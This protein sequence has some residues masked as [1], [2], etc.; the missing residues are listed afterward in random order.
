MFAV[1]ISQVEEE[2]LLYLRRLFGRLSTLS[3]PSLITYRTMFINLRRR[4][5]HLVM[6]YVS[7]PT[8]SDY[9]YS[10]NTQPLSEQEIR[11]IMSQ[12]LR[13]LSFL[14]A[15]KI[16][17]RDIKPDNILY[18]RENNRLWLIDFGVSKLMSE[19]RILKIMM[20]NTGTCEYKAP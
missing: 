7:H 13:I 1:K 12:L 19:R 3:H 9:I 16:C 8:L 10:R 5:C 4:T 20:T 6:D 14:H 2:H 15:N 11:E 18:D 17:H